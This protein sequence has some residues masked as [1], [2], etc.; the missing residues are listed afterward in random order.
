MKSHR[1]LQHSTALLVR[2]PDYQKKKKKKEEVLRDGDQRVAEA[3]RERDGQRPTPL[4]LSRR[5]AFRGILIGNG[6]N[7]SGRSTGDPRV[8]TPK[9]DR[10][11][12]LLRQEEFTRSSAFGFISYMQSVLDAVPRP[13]LNSSQ[14][15]LHGIWVDGRM[16]AWFFSFLTC[17]SQIPGHL[18]VCRY[19][20]SM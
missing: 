20:Q 12:C 2:T 15:N 7:K 16:R 6:G 10:D 17:S 8:P 18:F 9:P 1:H 19:A 3:E 11:S 14:L 5:I 13:L 4:A